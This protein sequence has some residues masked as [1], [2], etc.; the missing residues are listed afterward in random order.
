[1]PQAVQRAGELALSALCWRAPLNI[2]QA[3]MMQTLQSHHGFD[4]RVGRWMGVL[5]L[6]GLQIEASP[7]YGVGAE[8]CQA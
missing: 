1:M 4:W 6:R 8:K 3:G 5:A 2:Q 7:S